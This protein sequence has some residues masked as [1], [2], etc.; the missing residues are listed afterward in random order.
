MAQDLFLSIYSRN[1]L[2]DFFS[3]YFKEING[4][5]PEIR[6]NEGRA[7]LVDRIEQLDEFVASLSGYLPANA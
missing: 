1:D 4:Y 2:A 7:A 3:D 5:R 6:P